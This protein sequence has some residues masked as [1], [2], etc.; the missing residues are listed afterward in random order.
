MRSLH[1]LKRSTSVV[2]LLAMLAL[3]LSGCI[4]M[5]RS[6]TVNGDGSGSYTLTI[7]FSEQLVSLASDQISSNMDGFGAKVK[8]EGG[9]YRH[10]D[11]TGYSYWAY[12]RPFSSIAALNQLLQETP[13]NSASSGA[14]G[15]INTSSL[16]QDTLSF[17][18]QPG[19]ISN[20]FHVTGH[21]SL[22]FPQDATNT[23][24]ID[25]SQYLNDMRESFAVTMPGWVTSHKGGDVSGNT[26][27]YTVH[28][29]QEANVDVVGG[30]YN[31]ALL[32]PV[33]IGAVVVLALIIIGA[34]VLARRRG[35]RGEARVAAPAYVAA[36]PDAPTMP[37]TN[38][39]PGGFGQD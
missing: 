34:I 39:P 11:D 23:G 18:E 32:L 16:A 19:L 29:G 35:K 2:A 37:G 24:G 27:S 4:H 15:G 8:S 13:S 3:S 28:Y 38:M 12:T 36:G 9:S 5:D 22:K 33:G 30:G 31:T 7:G 20:T 17:A 14:T 26:V 21:M 1:A 25:V 6:V 10:Y